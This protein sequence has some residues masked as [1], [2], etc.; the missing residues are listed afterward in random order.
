MNNTRYLYSIKHAVY[1]LLLLL[2]YVLQTVPGLFVLFGAKPL[3]VIPAAI[4]IAIMEGEFVGGMYGAFAGLLCDM[5]GFSLF[6]FN[7][8]FVSL[9]CIFAGLLVIYLMHGNLRACLLFVLL[10]ALFCKS[11]EYLFAFGMWHLESAWKIYL[12]SVLPMVVYTALA[13][14]PIYYLVRGF[15]TRFTAAIES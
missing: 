4:A 13:A 1:A 9:C 12:Y 10:T 5:G 7:A 3:L 11:L 14:I 8:F 15:Y 6:G 2:L